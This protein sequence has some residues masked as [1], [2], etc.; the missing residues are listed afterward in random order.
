[1][2]STSPI[3]AAIAVQG[4]TLAV[5]NSSSSPDVFTTIANI[6]DVSIPTKAETQDITNV[7]DLWRRRIATLL[8]IGEI[9]FTI[10]WV[11]EETTHRNSAGGGA[12]AT[13]LRYLLVGRVSNQPILRD[14]QVTYP[15]GNAGSVDSFPAYVTSFAVTAKVGDVFRAQVTL[16]S[17]G[18]A[19]LV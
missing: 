10:F 16:S 2:P 9:T 8:D 3:A 13:G 14:W 6:T 17:S 7:G 5:S 11:M 18:A 4:L 19:Q 12:V 15:D 1:M